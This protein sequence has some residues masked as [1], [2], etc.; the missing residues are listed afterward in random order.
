[1]S[2]IHH[3]K[4]FLFDLDGLLVNTEEIHYQAYKKALRKHG[5]LLDWDFKKY[6]SF[7]HYTSEGV[8]ERVFVEFPQLKKSEEA[9][10]EVYADKKAAMISFLQEEPLHIMP[11]AD[12]FLTLLQEAGA[13]CCVV[14]H[15]PLELVTIIRK[16]HPILDTIPFWMTRENY[17]Q[18][19]PDPECYLKAIQTYSKPGDPVIGFEDTPR[20]IEAL[21]KTSA[22]PVLI[23]QL[24][25]PEIPSF[26]QRGVLHFPSFDHILDM[27]QKA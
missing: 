22:D 18:P 19:K 1:M 2:W 17:R 7:A 12:H 27:L 26:T 10:N 16:K 25:Y 3:Y 13:A 11:G 20:G 8:K 23:S 4:L 9:W 24:A 21:L 6:C 15:S 14:T 5:M